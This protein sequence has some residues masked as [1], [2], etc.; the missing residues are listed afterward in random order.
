MKSMATR[1]VSD[2]AV[3]ALHACE[4]ALRQ[5][6]F[7]LQL[8]GHS[9]ATRYC[10]IGDRSNQPKLLAVDSVINRDISRHACESKVACQ[11]P[12]LMINHQ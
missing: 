3:M 11:P 5:L 2:L 4:L 9:L 10:I 7:D 1:I 12:W 6:V 8:Y